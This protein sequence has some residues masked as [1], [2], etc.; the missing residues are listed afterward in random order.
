M[1]LRITAQDLSDQ[2]Q[3]I[4]DDLMQHMLLAVEPDNLSTAEGPGTLAEYLKESH[5]L[6]LKRFNNDGLEMVVQCPNL[7]SFESLLNDYHSGLLNEVVERCLVTDVIKTIL[8]MDTV[9]LKTAIEEESELEMIR[10]CLILMQ[11]ISFVASCSI[12]KG[13]C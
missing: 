8:N 11:K 6:V 3:E 4:F 7:K 5:N 12:V 13:K 10:E 1:R 2:Q 9:R